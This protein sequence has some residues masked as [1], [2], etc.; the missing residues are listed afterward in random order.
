LGDRA[1]VR[2][3]V[4]RQDPFSRALPETI[5]AENQPVT[6]IGEKKRGEITLRAIV[7]GD[8]PRALLEGSGGSTQI[9][10][11]GDEV[12]GSRVQEIGPSAVFLGDGRRIRLDEE[13]R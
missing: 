11:R 8:N 4:A 3:I 7:M 5:E 2:W 6:R 12:A 10:G 13:R 1:G 9:V